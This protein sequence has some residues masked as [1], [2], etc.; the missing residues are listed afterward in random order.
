MKNYKVR[1]RKSAL[2]ELASLWLDSSDRASVNRAVQ[3]IES[4]LEESPTEWGKELKEDLRSFTW[5]ALRVL[6]YVVEDKKIV[7]IVTATSPSPGDEG[8]E[9]V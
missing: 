3:E 4:R 9:E 1:W 7:R 8:T 5:K 6:F 2:N